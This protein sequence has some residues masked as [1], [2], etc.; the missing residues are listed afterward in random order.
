MSARAA[1]VPPGP[2]ASR[3]PR[4]R[5]REGL[6]GVGEKGSVGIVIARGP[7]VIRHGR[8]LAVTQRAESAAAGGGADG[9][10]GQ[11]HRERTRGASNDGVEHGVLGVTG[12]IRGVGMHHALA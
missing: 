2:A 8:G 9:R 7:R 6:S 1:G 5:T 10:Q 11:R 3:E 12:P 4:H